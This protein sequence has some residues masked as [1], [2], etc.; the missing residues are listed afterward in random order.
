M[1]MNDFKEKWKKEL[2]T[3][4]QFTQQEKTQII[5]KIVSSQNNKIHKGNWAYNTVLAGFTILGLFFIMITLSDRSFTLNTMTL[6]SRHLD[7]IEFT[8]NFYWFLIIYILT[9]F[10]ITAL[11]FTIIKTT[12]WEN[13]KWI[14]YIKIY[15]ERKYVPL[16]IFFYFLLA[17]PTFLVVNI[18]QILFLQLWLVLIVSALNC[19]YLLWCI[20]NSEQAACPHCGCQFSSRKIFSMSW[21]AYRTKCDKCN[22]RIFHSTSSKKKNSSMFPVLFLTY[23]ILGFF[24]FP[25]PF[26][27]M[28][29]LLNSLV[30]NLYISKFT[31]SF[32]K[33]DEPLW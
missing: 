14:L 19:I 32:S 33:D 16:L 26:I 12:R 4:L 27:L 18:L 8:S 31:M 1:E 21:N 11:I 25:F 22:E 23:F 20:R 7:E 29:F 10:T 2:D 24:Q 17:I 15:A 6:G 3:N 13:K 9:V 28:S 5:N 30:F